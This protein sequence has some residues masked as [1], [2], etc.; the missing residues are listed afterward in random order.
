MAKKKS[1]I[2]SHAKL[3]PKAL[4]ISLGIISALSIFFLGLVASAG[5]GQ[6]LVLT[7]GSFYKGYS[8]GILGSLAGGIWGF[9][10]GFIVGYVM[11]RIYN[12][13]S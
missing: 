8:P 3:N 2:P 10:E 9:I 4:G 1:T 13:V 12:K 7:M 6:T 11:A 5:W